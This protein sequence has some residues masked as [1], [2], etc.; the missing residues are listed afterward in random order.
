MPRAP[1]CACSAEAHRFCAEAA[2][3]GSSP[4]QKGCALYGADAVEWKA[5]EGCPDGP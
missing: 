4:G 5:K 3:A 1:Q 2:C